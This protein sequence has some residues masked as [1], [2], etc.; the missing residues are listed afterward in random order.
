MQFIKILIL[1]SSLTLTACADLS[2]E[3]NEILIEQVVELAEGCVEAG[4]C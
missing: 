3:E 1:L 2:D 4:I